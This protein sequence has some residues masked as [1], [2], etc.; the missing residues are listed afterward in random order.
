MNLVFVELSAFSK[1][2]VEH[3][4]DEEY[5]ALQNELY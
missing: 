5:R 3:L 2:R 4:S 1:Y